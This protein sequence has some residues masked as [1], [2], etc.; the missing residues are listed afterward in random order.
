[1]FD[2]RFRI[3]HQCE[4]DRTIDLYIALDVANNFFFWPSWGTAV[5]NA[6]INI[7]AEEQREENIIPAFQWPSGVG[8]L[9]G[10]HFY[11][12]MTEPDSWTIVGDLA[13]VTF[14]YN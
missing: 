8:A 2:A 11:G 5:D 10:L 9:S 6:R 13:I 1:M 12:M 7:R 14:C 3:T 4:N